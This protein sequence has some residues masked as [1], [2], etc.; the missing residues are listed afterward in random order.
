MEVF[1]LVSLLIIV[2]VIL[3]WQASNIISIFFGSPF[4]GTRRDVVKKAL[5]LTDLKKGEVFYELGCGTG[6]VLIEAQKYNVKAMGFEISP[7]YFLMAKLRT[8]KY[9]NIEVRFQDICHVNLQKSDVVYCYLLPGFLKK[10]TPKFKKEL[11]KSARLA[12]IGFPVPG[13]NHGK[14][15]IVNNRKIFIYNK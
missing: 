10:L 12:S 14:I 11:K 2:L 7:F 9:K 6:E 1:F 15:I 8:W 5:E 3:L 4:V 13:L